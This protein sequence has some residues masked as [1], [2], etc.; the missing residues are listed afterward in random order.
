[1]L[2]LLVNCWRIAAGV[3]TADLPLGTR[4]MMSVYYVMTTLSSVGY[5]DITPRNAVGV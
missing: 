4:Y 5:G 2:A 1:M 3:S